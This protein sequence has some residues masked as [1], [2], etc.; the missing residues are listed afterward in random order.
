M[1]VGNI[2]GLI[3]FFSAVFCIIIDLITDC[4][5]RPQRARSCYSPYNKDYFIPNFFK[6]IE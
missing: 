4:I 1:D 3:I 5:D 6:K 2:I